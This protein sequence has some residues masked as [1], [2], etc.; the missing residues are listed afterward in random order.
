MVQARIEDDD[1]DE[2]EV[3]E[4]PVINAT[5]EDVW[6]EK[7]IQDQDME[8]EEGPQQEETEKSQED[9]HHQVEVNV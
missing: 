3:V 5:R 1:E 2:D 9:S 6:V 7:E 8:E 4:G